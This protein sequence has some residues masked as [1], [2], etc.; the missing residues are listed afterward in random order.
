[1]SQR[2]GQVVRSEEDVGLQLDVL[3]IYQGESV[4]DAGSIL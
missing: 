3:C 4:R 2:M 1:M